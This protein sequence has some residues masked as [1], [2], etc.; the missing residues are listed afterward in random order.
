MR[1]AGTVSDSITDGPG[2]RFAVFLQGCPHRCPGC[3]NPGTWASDGGTEISADELSEKLDGNPLADG[4]TLSGG[5]PFC[6]AAE[7]A[8]LAR[9]AHG[10]GKSVWT[11]TGFTWEQL[12]DMDDPDRNAL[13]AQTDVLVDGRFLEEER[14]YELRFRGSRNQRLIDVPASLRE[15]RV[16]LWEERD[17]FSD[18]P[19][20]RPEG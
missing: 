2:L 7:C 13:L 3:H 5:E 15:G 18:L 10:R 17:R 19:T 6:Q 12:L 11:Y 16:V 9:L 4:L 8:E 20:G 1:V 14:S